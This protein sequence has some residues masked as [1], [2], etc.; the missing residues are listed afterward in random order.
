MGP[1]ET[2]GFFFNVV[3]ITK[4]MS[5]DKIVYLYMIK[6]PNRLVIQGNYLSIM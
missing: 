5:F 1:L 6:I 3:L 2:E 4:F